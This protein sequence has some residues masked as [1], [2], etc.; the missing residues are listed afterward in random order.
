M[1]QKKDLDRKKAE[2]MGQQP[3]SDSM[4]NNQNNNQNA[5]KSNSTDT[6]VLFLF[7][8]FFNIYYIKKKIMDCFLF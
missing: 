5:S 1:E 3:N 7:N 8:I 2:Q 4:N 6:D